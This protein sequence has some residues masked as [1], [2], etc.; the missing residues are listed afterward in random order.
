M[1]KG[2]CLSIKQRASKAERI[3]NV[4]QPGSASGGVPLSH[5]QKARISTTLGH[6]SI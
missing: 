1:W 2:V 5:L 3:P 4:F 6:V